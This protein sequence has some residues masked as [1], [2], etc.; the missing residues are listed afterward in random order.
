MDAVH[1]H[2]FRAISERKV[3]SDSESCVLKDVVLCNDVVILSRRRPVLRNTNARRAEPEDGEPIRGGIWQG[4]EQQRTGDTE[5]C[6]V[7]AD[8]DCQRKHN[9]CREARRLRERSHRIAKVLQQ[10]FDEFRAAR[11]ARLLLDLL[12]S[13]QRQMR[14]AYRL[15]W[16]EACA[17]ILLRF[18]LEMIA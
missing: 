1:L 17:A 7:R 3:V 9:Q 18:A 5:D 15:I 2:R 10:I 6:C 8:A 11:I 12:T 13:A 14:S 4:L 16:S